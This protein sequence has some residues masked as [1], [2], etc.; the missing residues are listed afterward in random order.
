MSMQS[1]Y[2][3]D[4]RVRTSENLVKLC[5]DINTVTLVQEKPI[6]I[7]AIKVK[8]KIFC[9]VSDMQTIKKKIS[10]M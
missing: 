2:L 8:V 4:R 3:W 10:Y 5:V 1:S 7:V 9:W 6:G